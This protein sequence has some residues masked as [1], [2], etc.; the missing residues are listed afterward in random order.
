VFTPREVAAAAAA[1][2]PT[3]LT[4]NELHRRL[5][6]V[7][8]EAARKLMKDGLVRGVKLDESSVASICESCEWAKGTRKPIQ[9]V[10]QRER[11][12]EIG[13]EVHSDLWG[14][15]PVETAS[16]QERDLRG[17]QEV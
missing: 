2:P 10:R 14:P 6:H 16:T 11:A 4:I 7:A 8:H 15:A 1:R 3:T 13:E 12:S 9:K 5:G 17:L